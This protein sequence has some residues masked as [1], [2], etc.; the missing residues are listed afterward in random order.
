MGLV[1]AEPR[2]E[3]SILKFL[4]ILNYNNSHSPYPSDTFPIFVNRLNRVGW[5]SP[6]KHHA[7][8]HITYF[9]VGDA[10]PTFL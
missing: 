3:L 5:A 1:A 2:K 8:V 6:T 7:L 9:L 4:S 10:H